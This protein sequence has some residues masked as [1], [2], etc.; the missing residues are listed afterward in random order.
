MSTFKINKSFSIGVQPESYHSI[1]MSN[2][3]VYHF[4]SRILDYFSYIIQM[5]KV[6]STDPF[7]FSLC[8]RAEPNCTP[9]Y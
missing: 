6:F 8:F 9:R 5:I 1:I 4:K 2:P 3:E 7:C